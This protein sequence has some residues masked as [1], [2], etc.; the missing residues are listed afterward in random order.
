MIR[1]QFLAALAASTAVLAP[2][3]LHAATS[4]LGQALVAAKSGDWSRAEAL[5]RRDGP[6]GADLIQWQRLRAGNGA[7][8]EYFAFASRRADW[9]G[10]D[11]L[12]YLPN[13]AN[14]PVPVFFGMNFDGNHTVHADPAITLPRGWVRNR[15]EAG[16]TDHRASE[17]GRGVVA[18]RWPI[19]A[20][21]ARGYGLATVFY[22]DVDPDFDDGFVN[23]VHRALGHD[24]TGDAW[25]A[26]AAWAWGYSRAL[27]YLESL[28]T[29]DANRII[30]IGH[31]RLG[32]TALWAAAE[33]ERFAM[34]ISNNSGCAGAAISRR[35]F[36]ETIFAINE[37]FPQWFCTNYHAYSD[38]EAALPF[39]QH[40]LLTL[41]APRPVYVASAEDDRWA[42]PRGEFLACVYASPAYELLGVEGI[43]TEGESMPAVNAPEHTG[44]IGYHLRTGGHDLTGYDWE[45]YM[46]FADQHLGSETDE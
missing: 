29:I 46:D 17:A 43:G 8:A 42:D 39:D 38:N 27:D 28:G 12:L 19:E 16:A 23:G 6:L 40:E 3:V 14:G 25:G 35:R 45:R 4:A 18:T 32:K 24:G 21:L 33:D 31:S 5:A 41:I 26:V 2:A 34:S 10:M 37:R 15:D 7:F 1:R 22:G 11:L 9:P 30:A 44:R 36:G 13:G 20:I